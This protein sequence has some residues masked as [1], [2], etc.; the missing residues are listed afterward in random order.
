MDGWDQKKFDETLDAY[1]R[2]SSRTHQEIVNTKAYY[3]AR[4][5]LWLTPKADSYKMKQQ[6]GGIVTAK[7]ENK[8]GKL[9]KRRELQ[10]V[11]GT[12]I[13]APLVSLI[14][15]ARRGRAGEKGLYGKPMETA[16]RELLGSRARSIAFIKSGWL[17]PIRDIAPFVKDKKEASPMDAASKQVG[18][19]KGE[20]KPATQNVNPRAEIVNLA[21]ARR[22]S[23]QALIK[24]G[25]PAL[26]QALME[27]DSSMN[28]YIERKMAPATQEFNQAQT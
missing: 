19:P 27:E 21:S 5:A 18:R 16:G 11:M 6:L 28:E 22:D 26:R 1:A 10:L 4:K 8:R 3:V 2:V 20:G 7:R 24:Y 25:E 14:I 9:V 12:A 15:N 23:R 17:G 13:P